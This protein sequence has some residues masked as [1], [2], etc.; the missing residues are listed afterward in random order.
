M[1][2][3]KFLRYQIILGFIV[4]CLYLVYRRSHIEGFLGF[5]DYTVDF[6]KKLIDVDEHKNILKKRCM[7]GKYNNGPGFDCLRIGF[8][9]QK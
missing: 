4:L 5:S 8:Y 6:T 7:E 3:E 9:C 1:Y 2:I